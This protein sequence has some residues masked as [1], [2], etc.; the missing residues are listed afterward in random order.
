MI[1]IWTILAGAPEYPLEDPLA[2]RL[3]QPLARRRGVRPRSRATRSFLQTA[4]GQAV[5][6]CEPV[7]RCR[8][9]RCKDYLAPRAAPG[10]EDGLLNGSPK[11]LVREATLTGLE[12]AT[13]AVTG[14]RANQLR[15]RALLVLRTPNGIRTRVTAVKGRGPRPLDDG[16]P[17]G[18]RTG[19]PE[20]SATVLRWEHAKHRAPLPLP[21]KR[22]D[23]PINRAGQWFPIA[24]PSNP[25]ATPASPRAAART[26]RSHAPAWDNRPGP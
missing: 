3:R 9:P 16:S 1:V 20:R 4:V 11:R 24:R 8:W 19:R 10:E 13:F 2:A 23:T 21:P 15:H 12:P 6:G 25:T 5:A 26:P 22:V 17:T 18:W 7:C 14:R